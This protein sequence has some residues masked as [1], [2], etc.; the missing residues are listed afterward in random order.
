[1]DSLDIRK[2]SGC[3]SPALATQKDR[4]TAVRTNRGDGR[5]HVSREIVRAAILDFLSKSE[6]AFTCSERTEIVLSLSGQR[7]V[8]EKALQLP[9]TTVLCTVKVSHGACAAWWRKNANLVWTVFQ[10][11]TREKLNIKER[12]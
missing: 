9:S 3:P 4:H 12:R 8:K 1:M 5:N 10:Q 6:D 7:T 2:T 11:R